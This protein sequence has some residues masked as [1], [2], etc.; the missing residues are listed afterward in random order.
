MERKAGEKFQ[1]RQD[2]VCMST[3]PHILWNH[4]K[5]QN[6]EVAAKRLEDVR[7]GG[8]LLLLTTISKS[9]VTAHAWR[10]ALQHEVVRAKRNSFLTCEGPSFSNYTVV[11]ILQ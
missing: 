8:E 6:Q 2:N 3:V 10:E 4:D 7:D 11:L 5:V 9:T 1:N